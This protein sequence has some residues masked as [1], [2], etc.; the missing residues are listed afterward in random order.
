MSQNQ[1]ETLIEFVLDS[2]GGEAVFLI[3]VSGWV[4]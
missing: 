3:S 1:L 4:C 2:E